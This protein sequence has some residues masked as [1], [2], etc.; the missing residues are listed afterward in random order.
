VGLIF[1][2]GTV[3]YLNF[4]RLEIISFGKFELG[5]CRGQAAS[6]SVATRRTMVGFLS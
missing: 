5:A 4:F 3:G 2:K 1:D 6:Q